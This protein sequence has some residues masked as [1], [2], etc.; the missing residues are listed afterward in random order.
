[1]KLLLDEMYTPADRRTTPRPR[2]R[3][4]H[5][6]RSGVSRARR[7]AGRGGVGGGHRR[8]Q[9]ARVRKRPGLPSPRD[10]RPR[11]RATA[12]TPD[13]HD[14]SSIPPRRP[15]DDRPSRYRARRAARR[16]TRSVY[17]AVH[18]ARLTGDPFVPQPDEPST[19]LADR[20]LR[21]VDASATRCPSDP[22]GRATSAVA[23]RA[24]CGCSTRRT[25]T[26]DRLAGGC[27]CGRAG[28]RGRR[29]RLPDSSRAATRAATTAATARAGQAGA[30]SCQLRAL[31][32]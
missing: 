19:S 27:F 26:A 25:V 20:S 11:R 30:A 1:M 5:C 29:E 8:P 14:R 21:E 7:R 16:R 32:V 31:R 18:E 4:R 15:R 12:P 24:E 10:T 6:A 2:P 17:G 13:L 23:S 9:S 28:A 3:C 22:E